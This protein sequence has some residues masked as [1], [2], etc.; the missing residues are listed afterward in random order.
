[1]LLWEQNKHK[2]KHVELDVYETGKQTNVLSSEIFVDCHI[3]FI[4]THIYEIFYLTYGILGW[5]S[6]TPGAMAMKDITRRLSVLR[7]AVFS[8][9]YSLR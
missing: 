3:Q 9:R 2:N 1:M 8:D 4:Y 6:H 7:Q 5:A